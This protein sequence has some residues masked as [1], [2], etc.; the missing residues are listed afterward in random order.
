MEKA[1]KFFKVKFISIVYPNSNIFKYIS[2]K[3]T[4]YEVLNPNIA[5]LEQIEDICIFG[6]RI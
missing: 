3:F 1:E 4:V 5:A 6:I 2:L